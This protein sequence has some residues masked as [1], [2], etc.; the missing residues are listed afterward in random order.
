[1]SQS[2]LYA[3]HSAST[4]PHPE[5]IRTLTEVT[6][7]IYANPSSIHQFGGQADQLVQRARE[8]I[9]QAIRVK[10]NEVMF[11]S[12]ATESN[13]LAIFGVV[14]ALQAPDKRL[15]VIVSQVEHASV[16]GCYEELKR[17]GVDVT[18]L[19]VNAQGVVEPDQLKASLRPNTV[20][21]SIMHVNNEI[22][23]IQPLEELGTMIKDHSRAIFHVDGVQGLGKLPIDLER[24]KVD[25]YSLSGHKIRGPK[26]AGILVRRGKFPMKPLLHGGSQEN[27]LRPGTM[28]VPSIV[29][30]SKS[31]RLAAEGQPK[32]YQQLWELRNKLIEG[33]QAIP[34]LTLNSPEDESNAA[35]HII[36]VSFV[37]MK[38]EVVVHAMERKGVV[39]ST[40]SACSSKLDKPSRVLMAATNDLTRAS[41]GLRISLAA[42]MSLQDI[43]QIC[44]ALRDTVDELKGL[45][46]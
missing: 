45:I 8:V 11:T 19:P 44:T 30:L 3:D 15:H 39:L 17:E 12:G 4:P 28:N 16:Y 9:A 23:S 46:R 32:A 31:V 34:E 18:F 41:S 33:I 42:E 7:R 38:P 10:P 43:E 26:G 5:V 40:Q 2:L 35:P 36:N 14:R 22:G 24:W 27:G 20:L 1:M 25:L 6:E 29:A 13:N 37:G 21:V